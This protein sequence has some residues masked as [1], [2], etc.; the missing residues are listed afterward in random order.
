MGFRIPSPYGIGGG[1]RCKL[2][3]SQAVLRSQAFFPC[4][5]ICKVYLVQ[6][7]QMMVRVVFAE[8]ALQYVSSCCSNRSSDDGWGFGNE[9]TRLSFGGTQGTL[10]MES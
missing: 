9:V 10:A 5:P 4:P 1:D 8:K 2:L 6:A 7:Y 3:F